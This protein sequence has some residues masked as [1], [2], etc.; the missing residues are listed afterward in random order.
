MKGSSITSCIVTP[1]YSEEQSHKLGKKSFVVIRCKHE[2]SRGIGQ[3]DNA[4]YLFRFFW[5]AV[6]RNAKQRHVPCFFAG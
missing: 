6:K 5:N 1:N 2:E 3:F 4:R